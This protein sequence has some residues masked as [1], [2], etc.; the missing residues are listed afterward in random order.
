LADNNNGSAG[1]SIAGEPSLAEASLKILAPIYPGLAIPVV[2]LAFNALGESLRIVL[3]PT[4][5]D[6]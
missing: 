5:R 2:S 3:D 6:R 4:T 1:R